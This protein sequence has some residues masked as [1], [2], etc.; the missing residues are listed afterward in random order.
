MLISGVVSKSS[1]KI[2]LITQGIP[3]RKLTAVTKM[4][5]MLLVLEKKNSHY[6]LTL[7]HRFE[8]VHVGFTMNTNF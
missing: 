8:K 7:N 3:L 1:F 6:Y 4:S 2:N 5:Y